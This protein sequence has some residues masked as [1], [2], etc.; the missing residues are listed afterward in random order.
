MSIVRFEHIVDQYRFE[1]YVLEVAIATLERGGVT[2]RVDTYQFFTPTDAWGVPKYPE[3]TQK[4]GLDS[5]FREEICSFIYRHW[6]ALTE[7]DSW[8]GTWIDPATGMRHL[9][10]TI[11]YA[12]LEEARR[13]AQ[14]R[15]RQSQQ[16]ILALY[17]FQSATTF[18]L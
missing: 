17:N 7:P 12:T 2:S 5:D 9:D 6:G 15:S 10:I 4:V 3:K 8:L 16:R 14:M 11:I 13:E 18:F 1:K